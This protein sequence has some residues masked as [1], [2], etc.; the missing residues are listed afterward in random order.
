[1]VDYAKALPL[2][3][4][5]SRVFIEHNTPKWVVIHKTAGMHTIEDLA[6]WFAIDPARASTHYGVGLDGRVGQFVL[7]QDGAGGNCCTEPG[8]AAFLPTADGSLVNLNWFT[9]SIEHLDPATDNST[10]CTPEQIQAS[11][12]LILDICKRHNIPMRLG[13]AQGGVIFHHDIAPQSR[14]RCPGNY[15]YA[16]LQAF[17]QRESQG[18]SSVPTGWKD[19]QNVLTAPNGQ[20]V[21]LGFRQYVLSHTWDPA[22][23]PL[24]NEVGVPSVEPWKAASPS[25]TAQIFT[26]TRLVW[27]TVGGVR[28]SPMGPY[29]FKLLHM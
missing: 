22:N 28:Q 24:E 19:E 16:E 26:D 5:R 1:M 18:L 25:G 7:E 20:R 6:H 29:L 15:P 4:D 23:L 8:H 10:P 14:A 2:F 11:F 13:D 21:I 9:I 27:D 12:A 3:V 17:L